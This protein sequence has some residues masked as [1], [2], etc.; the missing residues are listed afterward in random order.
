LVLEHDFLTRCLWLLEPLEQAIGGCTAQLVGRLQHSGDGNDFRHSPLDLIKA[1]Q[2]YIIRNTLA[3][4]IDRCLMKHGS[5]KGYP[6]ENEKGWY[7]RR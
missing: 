4:S 1:D 3:L 5:D 2:G 6:E 7:K